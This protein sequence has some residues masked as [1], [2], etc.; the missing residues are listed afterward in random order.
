MSEAK[1]IY[2]ANLDAVSA[3]VV[4]GDFTKIRQHIAIPNM[5]STTD[6]E[7]VMA[8]VEEFD[9]VMMDFRS[10]LLARGMVDYRRT[11]LEAHFV[12]GQSD[13]VAGRHRTEVILRN[14][15]TLP[16]YENHSVIMR[17]DDRWMGIWLQAIMDNTELQLLSPDIAAAQAEARRM[18]DRTGHRTA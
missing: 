3:A 4:A 9:I 15:A 2:Q 8:S 16:P 14:G 6:S 17:I 7:I 5:M 11:C 12:A 18:L 1:R 10:E 13:M